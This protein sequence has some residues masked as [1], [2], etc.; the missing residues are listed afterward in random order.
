MVDGCDTAFEG[1]KQPRTSQATNAAVGS[2]TLGHQ[3]NW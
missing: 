3:L 1:S 2:D